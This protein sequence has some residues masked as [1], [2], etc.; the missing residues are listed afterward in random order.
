MLLDRRAIFY[1]ALF[2]GAWGKLRALHMLAFCSTT[3]RLSS[4]YGITGWPFCTD[5]LS[6]KICL[7]VAHDCFLYN[8]KEIE[9][10]KILRVPTTWYWTQ[11]IEN[12]CQSLTTL[13]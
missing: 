10:S 6:L 9:E 13:S 5:H 12:H 7:Y 11:F 3:Q 1:M 8:A 2:C 4:C